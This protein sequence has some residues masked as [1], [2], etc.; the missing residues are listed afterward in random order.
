[1]KWA[2][3]YIAIYEKAYSDALHPLFDTIKQQIEKGNQAEQVDVSVVVIARNEETR[4]SAC[5]WSLSENITD[6]RFEV[7]GVDNGSD[8]HTAEIYQ[9][10]GLNYQLELRAG[11]GF[12]RN[13]GH[14]VARGKYC[15]CVDS[16]TIYP[17]GYIQTVVDVLKQE[18]VVATTGFY[19]FIATKTSE[20]IFFWFYKYIRMVHYLL[21]MRKRPELVARGMVLSYR[22]ALGREKGFRTNIARG[23]DGTLVYDLM[24]SGKI[25]LILDRKAQV[26]TG[27]R[28][29]AGDDSLLKSLFR[30]VAKHAKDL[31]GYY[32]ARKND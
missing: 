25:K 17:P 12:A 4:L 26:L 16:D 23:E 19:N 5:L 1:M 7:I 18:G 8:D 3:K 21:Q 11:H 2:E 27:M 13:K 24:P 9:R 29:L 14:E 20:R 15:L 22:T 32:A 28:S 31:R 6:Y 10:C 30:R